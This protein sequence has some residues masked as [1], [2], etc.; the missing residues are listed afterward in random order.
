MGKMTWI[1][2]RNNATKPGFHMMSALW[3]ILKLFVLGCWHNECIM[4]YPK[5]SSFSKL[6]RIL[7]STWPHLCLDMTYPPTKFGVDWSKETQVIAWKNKLMFDLKLLIL[8]SWQGFHSP[9]DPK[10]NLHLCLDMTYPPASYRKKNP[11]VWRPPDH[12]HP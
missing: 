6:A 3:Y 8:S 11:N 5:T 1:I 4:I 9:V 12:R 2:T 7:Q 10:I